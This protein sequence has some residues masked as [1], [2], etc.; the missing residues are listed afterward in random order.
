MRPIAFAALL[1]SCASATSQTRAALDPRQLQPGQIIVALASSLGKDLLAVR[2]ALAADYGV[3]EAGNFLLGSVALE[4]VVFQ[5][6]ADAPLPELVERMNRDP[7]VR[8]AQANQ[9]FHGEG[10][11][12]G[13][14][15]GAPQIRADAARRSRTGKGVRVAV[16]DTG[17]SVAHPGLRDRIVLAQNFVEGGETSFARDLHGTAV[18]GLIAA[19]RDDRVGMLGIAPDA[20]ILAIKACWYARAE[21]RALCSSWT[22]AKAID[23]AVGAGAQV[24]NLSLT[25]PDDALLRLLIDKA[26]E[27]GIVVVAAAAEDAKGPGFPASLPGVIAVLS[28]DARGEARLPDW[29]A[30]TFAVVA[31]GVDVLS[32]V[33]GDGYDFLSGSSFAAAHVSG[34]VALLLEENPRLTAL[35]TLDLLKATSRLLPGNSRAGLVDACAALGKLMGAASC[36]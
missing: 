31:P 18:A 33:P 16:I 1:A 28:S 22:L 19:R 3:V 9:V 7:R 17:V 25:G 36:P 34:V 21:G 13:L 15:Y 6:A 30:R 24:L 26:Q 23:F 5:A 4:C 14:S 12:P 29:A 27:R 2:R 32:T 20:R 11:E 8:L 35:T 10:G